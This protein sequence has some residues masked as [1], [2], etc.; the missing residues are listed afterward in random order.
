MPTPILKWIGQSHLPST[1]PIA[2]QNASVA[3]SLAAAASLASVIHHGTLIAEL[4]ACTVLVHVCMCGL[5]IFGSQVS[6]FMGNRY[7]ITSQLYKRIIH[8]I[9]HSY[10]RELFIENFMN[11]SFEVMRLLNV[12]EPL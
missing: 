2:G 11:N 4:S 8:R 3:A 10:I 7:P 9:I 12:V 5:V 1:W 6:S